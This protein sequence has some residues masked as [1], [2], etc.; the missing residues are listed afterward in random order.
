MPEQPYPFPDDFHEQVVASLDLTVHYI[1][2][3]A[4]L[5]PG[6]PTDE[7]CLGE[8]LA[9]YLSWNGNRIGKACLRLCYAAMESANIHPLTELLERLFGNDLESH[10]PA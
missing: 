5:N 10:K 9:R 6:E 7:E 1:R 2:T 4:S 3:Y 8:A